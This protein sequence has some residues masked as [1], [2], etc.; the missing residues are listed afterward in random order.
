MTRMN[1][2]EVTDPLESSS[3]VELSVVV[4]IYNEQD[5]LPQFFSRLLPVLESLTARYEVICVND[6]STDQ[7]LPLLEELHGRNE[8]IVIVDFSRNFGKEIAL[9][10]GVDFARGDAVIPIDA[11]LQD[12]PELIAELVAKWREGYDVVLAARDD[13]SSDPLVKR[14]SADLFYR[15]MRRISHTPI[16]PDVG[17]FRLMSR[18]VV[19]AVRQLPERTRFMKGIFTWVGYRQAT[20]F[21]TRPTRA[22]GE[23][24]WRL[25][26]LWNFALDGIVSFSTFP[27]KIWSYLGFSSALI[28]LIYTTFIVGRTLITGVDVPGYASLLSVTLF[29]NG[30][31][32][33][34]LGILGEYIARIFIE[35]KKRPMYLVKQTRGI[36]KPAERG[37][38]DAAEI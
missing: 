17:D 3:G 13:R 20:V 29:F 24:K 26:P 12:P 33:V 37:R 21:Y 10:A 19:E 1:T 27:L 36:D 32:L 11:D 8:R 28:G 38:G 31:V 6:G 35:V 34:G 30:L 25:W 5:V 2:A 9:T 7:T 18:S 23:T 16:P 15:M 14:V 22:A 4:P